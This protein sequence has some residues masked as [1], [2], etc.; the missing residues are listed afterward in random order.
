MTLNMAL[1]M[2]VEI[3]EKND[4]HDNL[5]LKILIWANLMNILITKTENFVIN[6]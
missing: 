6:Y 5:Y 1:R 3:F 2:I 4:Q